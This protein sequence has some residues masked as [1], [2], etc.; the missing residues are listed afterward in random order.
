MPKFTVQQSPE[1]KVKGENMVPLFY[2]HVIQAMTGHPPS[3]IR[4]PTPTHTR[5][6]GLDL[7]DDDDH[8]L[9]K[10]SEDL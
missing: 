1:N 9:S 3:A 10:N 5:L 6:N 2:T 7:D 8:P 4:H